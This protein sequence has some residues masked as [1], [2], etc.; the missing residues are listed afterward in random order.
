MLSPV[1]LALG[2]AGAAMS[3]E[4]VARTPAWPAATKEFGLL[5]GFATG[6]VF[7]PERTPTRFGQALVRF[8]LH[9]GPTGSGWRRGNFA[10][11]AEGV[12]MTI[13]QE[14]RASGGGLNLLFRYTWAADRWRPMFLAGAGVYFSDREVPPGETTTNFTPQGGVGLQYLVRD[15]LTLGGEY[16]FHHLSN[17]GQTETNPG[18]N[19]HLVLFGIS[20]YR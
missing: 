6:K 9:L 3:Q 16:R 1:I 4:P 13:D 12:F 8:A 7:D 19:S 14:P 15:N 11:V 10:V 17:N 18:M 20:W 5:G 2:L